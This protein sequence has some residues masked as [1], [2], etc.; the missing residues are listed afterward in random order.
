MRQWTLTVEFHPRAKPYS[1]FWWWEL[2]NEDGKPV[3]CGKSAS[4]TD[5][6]DDLT[7]A[8]DVDLND[9]YV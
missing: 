2:T 8:I 7:S 1:A 6:G 9:D 3:Q 5:L 4:L